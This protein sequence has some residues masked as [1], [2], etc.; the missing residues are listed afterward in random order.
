MLWEMTNNW[1][2]LCVRISV[3]HNCFLGV[4]I[5]VWGLRSGHLPERSNK[6]S[7]PNWRNL[8]NTYTHSYI[9]QT[10]LVCHQN[11]SSLKK[12]LNKSWELSWMNALSS[13]S[14]QKSYCCTTVNTDSELRFW[15]AI[16]I[17]NRLIKTVRT[18]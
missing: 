17:S 8:K 11:D 5:S 4:C 16:T 6:R 10:S 14:A 18:S 1:R 12:S 15:I 3:G 9:S 2:I 13:V 7:Y